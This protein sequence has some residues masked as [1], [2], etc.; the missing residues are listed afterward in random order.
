[1]TGRQVLGAVLLIVLATAVLP[2]AVAWNVNRRRVA[3]ASR[4]VPALAERVRSGGSLSDRDVDPWGNAYVTHGSAVL[5]WGPNGLLETQPG[6]LVA[7]G[8]DILAVK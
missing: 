3:T 4:E 1:M 5:S 2:P 7:G 8:D 6:A